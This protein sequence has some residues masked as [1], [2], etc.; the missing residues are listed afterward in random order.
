MGH[1]S[2]P[3]RPKCTAS[4]G[5]TDTGLYVGGRRLKG[6]GAVVSVVSHIFARGWQYLES[7]SLVL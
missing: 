3:S 5:D 4:V 6:S 1:R 7:I 2:V